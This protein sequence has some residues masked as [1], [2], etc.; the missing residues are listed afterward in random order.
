[1]WKSIGKSVLRYR[2]PLSILLV[3]A[4]VFMGWQASQV[5]LSYEF[6]RAIP[7]DNPKYIAYQ[8]FKKQFGEDGNMLVIGVQTKDFF[9]PAF[10]NRYKA[11]QQDIKKIAGVEA[12]L[13]VPSAVTLIKNE[14]T[15][16]LQ[17]TPLFRDT[18]LSQEELD[19]SVANFYN[20]PFYQGLLYNAQTDAWLMGVRINRNIM[21][22]PKRTDVVNAI[23]QLTNAFE[24][25]QK[26]T[27]YLS[28]L[29]LI[30]TM[31]ATKI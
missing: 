26:T 21:S 15:E 7:T 25:G 4:T 9:K 30:R 3:V 27:V 20:L 11:L 16:K 13:S 18:V 14:A 22:S 23:V 6:S 28:G 2:L 29:P 31:M 8:N 19:S 12:I 5:K 17:P 1:M 10:F 24:R